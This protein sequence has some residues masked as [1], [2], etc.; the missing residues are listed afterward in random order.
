LT[1]YEH[2]LIMYYH[3][4]GGFP[5]GKTETVQAG[6]LHAREQLL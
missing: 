5:D 2:M 4:V 1:N 3:L 6:W